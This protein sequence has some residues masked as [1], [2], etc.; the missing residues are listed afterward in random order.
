M[1]ITIV[2]ARNGATV[3][4]DHEDEDSTPIRDVFAFD[5]EDE[6]IGLDGLVH[7]LYQIADEL[8]SQGSKYSKERVEVRLVHGEDYECPLGCNICKEDKDD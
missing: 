2:P 8:G 4:V 3:T 7:M 1:K 6:H 5:S